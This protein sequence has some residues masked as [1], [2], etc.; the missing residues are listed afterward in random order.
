MMVLMFI[1]DV[2][3]ECGCKDIA[4]AAT[5]TDALALIRARRFDIALLDVNLDGDRSYPVADALEACGTPFL[6]AT[7]YGG[8]GIAQ[9]YRERPLV[10]KPFDAE[11]LVAMITS[12]LSR[13]R[14]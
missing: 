3:A 1:E 6:F 8:H 11:K 13:Q 7:G 5:V 14:T 12:V 10:S 9:P 4:A 2:L